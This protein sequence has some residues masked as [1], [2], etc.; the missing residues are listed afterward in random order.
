MMQVSVT[1]RH[2]EVTPSLRDHALS[3]VEHDFHEFPRVESVHVILDTQKHRHIAE[4]DVRA[5]NH[6]HIEGQ[7]ESDDMYHSIN[8][9]V[10]KASRQLRKRRDKTQD[11]R[12]LGSIAD[13][14]A[15]AQQE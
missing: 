15:S 3:K 1:C 8:E 4:V 2:M 11:H 13:M 7:A 12:S 5:K 9:A 10:E 6:I 14:E